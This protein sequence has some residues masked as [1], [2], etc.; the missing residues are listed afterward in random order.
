MAHSCKEVVLQR[1]T[2]NTPGRPTPNTHNTPKSPHMRQG[3]TKQSDCILPE[4]WQQNNATGQ[5]KGK[6][7]VP[8]VAE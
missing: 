1:Y 4:Q 7:H 5:C 8:E 3:L 6:A 2:A